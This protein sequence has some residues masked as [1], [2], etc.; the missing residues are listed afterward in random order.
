MPGKDKD[1]KRDVKTQTFTPPAERLDQLNVRALSARLATVEKTQIKFLEKMDD[2]LLQVVNEHRRDNELSHD[3]ALDTLDRLDKIILESEH[4]RDE[5]MQQKREAKTTTDFL[6]LDMQDDML[7][8]RLERTR[9]D[10]ERAAQVIKKTDQVIGESQTKIEAIKEKQAV[11]AAQS[12]PVFSKVWFRERILPD[13]VKWAVIGLALGTIQ[14]FI[15]P[16][17]QALLDLL[18]KSFGG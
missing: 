10:R 3:L 5:L 8:Q 6:L 7:V 2:I 12:A 13:L 16:G 11:S 14:L 4:K 18:R 1:A 9:A 15:I 17:L